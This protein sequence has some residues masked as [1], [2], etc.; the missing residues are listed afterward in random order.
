MFL[1][2]ITDSH[3]KNKILLEGL[4]GDPVVYFGKTPTVCQD[5][6]KCQVKLGERPEGSDVTLFR[7]NVEGLEL[8]HDRHTI[9][10]GA[11]SWV[12]TDV[13]VPAFLV[14]ADIEPH[15][16]EVIDSSKGN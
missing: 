15:R 1:Y 12:D 5:V 4:I 11:P 8:L 16:L 10:S 14:Y 9:W 2:H 3:L 7:V 13:D 6:R